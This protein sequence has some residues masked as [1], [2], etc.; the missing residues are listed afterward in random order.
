MKV[1]HSLPLTEK[2][3]NPVVTIGTFDGVHIGHTKILDRLK[4]RASNINGQSVVITFN[5]HPRQVLFPDDDNLKLLSTQQ[6]KIELLDRNGID[7]L[8][9]IEFTRE[10]SR[11]T[12]LEF[13]RDILVNQVGVSE[14]IIGYDHHFGRNRE[15]SIESLKEMAQTFDFKVEEIPAEE[16]DEVTISST[17]IRKAI[18]EG[19]MHTA[20]AFLGYDFGFRGI[21]EHGQKLGKSLGFPTANIHIPEKVKIIPQK[22]VYAVRVTCNFQTHKG[23]MNIGYRPTVDN[24]PQLRIEVH[25]FDFDQDIYGKEIGVHVVH[26]LRDEQKFEGLEQLKT[27]IGKDVVAARSILEKA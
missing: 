14:L 26:K 20:N 8:I 13:I 4:K 16:I 2:L 6:E 7:I 5:P 21:V 18:T 24:S 11:L 3:V 15:G 10:F 1:F 19:D 12:A 25:I 9:I 17:K 23:V 22:G 27:Q